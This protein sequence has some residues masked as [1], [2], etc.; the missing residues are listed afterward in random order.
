MVGLGPGGEETL[1]PQAR[2][3]ISGADV[4]IGYST[5]IKLAK[6]Y[7]TNQTVLSSGMKKETD[8][9]RVAVE[10]ALAGKRVAVISSGD[11][12][13]YGMASPIL[14]IAPPELEV[15]VIPGV[16]AATATA[17]VL[18]APLTHDF[19]VIS[20]SDLLTPWETILR[21]LEAAAAADFVIV[22]YNPRSHGRDQ[23]LEVA[24]NVVLKHRAKET[25]LG[26]VKDCCRAGEAKQVT[27][28]GDMNIEDVDMTTTVII[29]NSQTKV[30]NG[31]M[32]TPR[33]YVI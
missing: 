11:P 19:A 1:T 5:Y 4:V 22:L 26:L 29:G 20:L 27:T 10:E 21:R 7:L 8:R 13:V 23:H 24:R 15:D 25:P 3:A 6:P 18:G 14:E 12:G 2:D 28:L 16:T 30:L 17:A 32:I 33:G 31:R 9:A